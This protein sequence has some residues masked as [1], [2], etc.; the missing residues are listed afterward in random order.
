MIGLMLLGCCWNCWDVAGDALF[1]LGDGACCWVA[2]PEGC[3]LPNIC[4]MNCLVKS[5]ALVAAPALSASKVLPQ[6]C[7]PLLDPPV[8]PLV[9]FD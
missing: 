9:T 2:A 3:P 1:R 5:S 7:F 4:D 8:P 6:S